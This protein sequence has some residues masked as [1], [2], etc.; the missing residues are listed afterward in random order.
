MSALIRLG[1][2]DDV[3]KSQEIQRRPHLPYHSRIHLEI[4]FNAILQMN[5]YLEKKGI[6]KEMGI[7]QESWETCQNVNLFNA[8]IH[9]WEFY[10][11]HEFKPDWE[12]EEKSLIRGLNHWEYCDYRRLPFDK[13]LLEIATLHTKVGY[14]PETKIVTSPEFEGTE[15]EC[16]IRLLSEI[17]DKC[18]LFDL[19]RTKGLEE[20]FSVGFSDNLRLHFE[21]KMRSPK[22]INQKEP[23][24]KLI[25]QTLEK[26]DLV[27]NFDKVTANSYN[28]FERSV[29]EHLF[30]KTQKNLFFQA[31]SIKGMLK[32]IFFQY[33]LLAD[34][35]RSAQKWS[36][37]RKKIYI[38][39]Q[40]E[41]LLHEYLQ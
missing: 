36:T 33:S 22:Y 38:K 40:I 24:I 16:L 2:F 14:D 19:T 8:L 15:T 7:T 18:H 13:R 17:G 21:I 3:L 31:P 9:D 37:E 4:F 30:Q 28:F 41:T 27:D 26:S 29:I 10:L 34:F 1:M 35:A 32:I 39:E 25:A 23:C 5:Q 11:D 20:L 12:N 6:Q